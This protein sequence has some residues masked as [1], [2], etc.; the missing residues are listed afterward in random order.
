[1]KIHRQAYRLFLFIAVLMTILWLPQPALA[2][3]EEFGLTL[4]L[5]N[6]QY[7]YNIEAMA[8]QDN[9]FFLEVRNTGNRPIT[10][11]RLSSDEPEGWTIEIKPAEINSLSSGVIETVD[12][13]IR[14][15]GKATKEGYRVPFIAQANETRKVE[16]FWVTVKP[17]QF[18]I[19]VWIVAGVVVVAGFVLVYLRF[20][21]QKSET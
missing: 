1:M 12:V 16:T 11:I 3:K 7:N 8:G 18:W 17:A 19:W 20:G 13:N 2:Q 6:S 21:R 15:V 4:S 14:P 9:R 5:R 10:N